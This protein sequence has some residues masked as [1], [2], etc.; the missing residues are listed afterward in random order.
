MTALTKFLDNF[1]HNVTQ[2]FVGNSTLPVHKNKA[3][4]CCSPA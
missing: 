2:Y 4:K 3:F 1:Y